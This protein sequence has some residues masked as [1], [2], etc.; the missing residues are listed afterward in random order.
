MAHKKSNSSNIAAG[1]LFVLALLFSAL[2]VRSPH[3]IDSR[4]LGAS[5]SEMYDLPEDIRQFQVR[6]HQVNQS[7][8]LRVPIL[9]YHYV[10]DV[11]DPK[12]TIR[13]SLNI[14]PNILDS[15]IKTLVDSGY[16]FL[17][18]A[19][20]PSYLEGK[21]LLPNK[22]IILSFD[23]GYEDFYTD[24]FPILKKYNARAVSYIITG[25]INKNNYMSDAQIKEIIN[26]HLV[27]IGA[28]TVHHA[29]LKGMSY[30][31]AK[32][33]IVQSKADLEN[34]FHIPV[35]S[36]AYPYG[37]FDVQSVELVKKAGFN[38]AIST[39]PGI[40]ITQDNIYYIYRIRPG[41]RTGEQLL[42]FLGQ[43]SF[44]QY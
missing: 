14:P 23:D 1:L 26:S 8:S 7:A 43:N 21:S 31:Q 16:T 12:D 36:F 35:V 18:P 25:S 2:I 28:H 29:Y 37:A 17:T 39:I 10:E 6:Y 30:N 11:A 42:K 44:T 19:D 22:P 24:A 38:N 4:V 34:E 13:K 27:E 9:L 5:S 40:E 41:V 15:Q 20:I 33:E 3:Q 32:S